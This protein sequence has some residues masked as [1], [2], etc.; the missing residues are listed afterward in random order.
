MIVPPEER[1]LHH[2]KCAFGKTEQDEQLNLRKAVGPTSSLQEIGERIKFKYT[3]GGVQSAKS[4]LW[5]YLQN[6][7]SCF[8]ERQ[9]TSKKDRWRE[10]FQ[11]K[12]TQQAQPIAK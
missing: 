3:G 4:R 11:I 6:P 7:Q 1:K 8:F 2:F 12:E 9:I 10:K 5:D